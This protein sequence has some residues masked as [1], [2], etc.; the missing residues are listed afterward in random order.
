M[1]YLKMFKLSKYRNKNSHIYP[2]NILKNKILDAKIYN[3]DTPNYEVRKWSEIENVKY[4]LSF[5]K[6]EEKNLKRNKIS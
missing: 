4:F 5:L 6:K 2:Y 1:V 3:L